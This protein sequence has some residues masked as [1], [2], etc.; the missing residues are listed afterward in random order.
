MRNGGRFTTA[1]G[2]RAGKQGGRRRALTLTAKQRSDIAKK[3]ARS[4]W[5]INGAVR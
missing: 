4:R 3:A 1:S 5:R 2:R